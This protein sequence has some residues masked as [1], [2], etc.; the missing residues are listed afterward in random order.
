MCLIDGPSPVAQLRRDPVAGM[1]NREG[2]K[3]EFEGHEDAG[4]N[5]VENLD[6]TVQ[7]VGWPRLLALHLERI[8]S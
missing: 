3:R 8:A 1:K 2:R 4:R 7:S 6:R 5:S